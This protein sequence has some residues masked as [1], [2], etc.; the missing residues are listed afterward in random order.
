MTRL[1]N[2][3]P[4]SWTQSAGRREHDDV[5]PLVGVEAWRQLVHQD[6]LL[7]LQRVLHRLLLDLVR[8]GDERLDDEEDD[9]GESERLRRSRGDTRAWVVGSQDAQ[10]RGWRRGRRRPSGRGITGLR[11][12][13]DPASR[14]LLHSRRPARSQPKSDPDGTLEPPSPRFAVPEWRRAAR[15]DG[16]RQPTRGGP[17][18][19]DG[20][21]FTPADHPAGG[22]DRHPVRL[23]LAR[24]VLARDTGT[25]A[26]QDVA[27]TIYEGA[28]PSSAASTRPSASSPS[29]ARWSSAS[30]SASSRPP[31]SPTCRSWPACR[32]GS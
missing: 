30:S 19:P 21:R 8:L 17:R 16:D 18:N 1:M 9:E 23:Y 10:Y 14:A 28:A 20:R 26:M 25:Q 4:S 32:S 13:F 11:N 6:V 3:V 24:D 15:P 27:G 22:H 12:G 7:R 31:R 5:A 2:G 29:S